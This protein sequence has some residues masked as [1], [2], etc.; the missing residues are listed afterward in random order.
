MNVYH[1]LWL[2]LAALVGFQI[3][4]TSISVDYRFLDLKE[5]LLVLLAVSSM[6]FTL[7]GIW[8]AFLYPNALRKIVSPKQIEVA[9]FSESLSE[10]RR[11]EGLVGSVLRSSLVVIVIMAVFAGKVLFSFFDMEEHAVSFVKA[12]LLSIVAIISVL[13]LES[14]FYVAYSNVMFI[15]D[16]HRKREDREADYD[17]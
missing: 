6:V 1:K 4:F 10:T 3:L 13:Q 16:L 12:A 17:I 8:I 9:D 15:N 7:M 11:L 5:Y 2:Y 14:I